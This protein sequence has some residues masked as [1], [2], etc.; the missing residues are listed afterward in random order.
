MYLLHLYNL[1]PLDFLSFLLL[2]CGQSIP[3]LCYIGPELFLVLIQFSLLS[4]GGG[5]ASY[6]SLLFVLVLMEEKVGWVLW[7]QEL[8]A[9]TRVEIF[10]IAQLTID[11]SIIFAFD[12]NHVEI[13]QHGLD[14]LVGLSQ[15]LCISTSWIWLY[16]IGVT[17]VGV[18]TFSNYWSDRVL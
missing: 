1:F 6:Y 9:F 3:M 4:L 18:R 11:I 7:D 8:S 2:Q 15:I 16:L 12:C 13:R 10:L 5:V 14:V 17:R